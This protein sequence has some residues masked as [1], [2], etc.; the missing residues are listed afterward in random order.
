MPMIC[1]LC[2]PPMEG[3]REWAITLSVS[4]N[5]FVPGPVLVSIT[6][7]GTGYSGNI[8]RDLVSA[9]DVLQQGNISILSRRCT[10]HPSEPDTSGYIVIGIYRT[11]RGAGMRG[12][13]GPAVCSV[14]GA[15]GSA[16]CVLCSQ[17][18]C[19]VCAS[20]SLCLAATSAG[21]GVS[22]VPATTPSG[23]R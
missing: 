19:M 1:C 5:I 15:A 6:V 7:E 2:F 8:Y 4:H 22:S 14:P 17:A 18:S 10:L 3:G 21:C 9:F 13:C 16:H 11:E 23:S 20:S 12:G